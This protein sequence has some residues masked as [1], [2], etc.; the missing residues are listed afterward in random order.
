M[1][2]NLYMYVYTHICVCVGDK[3]E[4]T[5]VDMLLSYGCYAKLP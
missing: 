4:M 3:A 2:A 5:M 1:H